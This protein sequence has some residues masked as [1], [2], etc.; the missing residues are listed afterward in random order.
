MA[1]NRAKNRYTNILAYDHS[2]V[3]LS[4]VDEPGSDYIN[5]CYIP[6]SLYVSTIVSQ[7]SCLIPRPLY[8]AMW[9]GNEAPPYHT[10]YHRAI[11]NH[12]AIICHGSAILNYTAIICHDSAILDHT[13]I[14]CHDSAILDHTS[15]YSTIIVCAILWYSE[16]HD[17]Q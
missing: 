15:Q 7:S 3:K 10:L 13:A 8:Y 9:P 12:T 16:S 2:R 4:F 5:A 6:V 14:I 17:I 11:L 1:D